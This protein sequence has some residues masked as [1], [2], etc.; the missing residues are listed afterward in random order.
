MGIK[1]NLLVF[2]GKVQQYMYG[3]VVTVF[4][5]HGSSW[6]HKLEWLVV[7]W[8]LEFMKYGRYKPIS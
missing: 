4:N 8:D 6:T 3:Q 7:S 1:L 5:T 2:Q